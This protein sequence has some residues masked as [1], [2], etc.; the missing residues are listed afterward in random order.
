V[1]AVR[2]RDN[3]ST[4]RLLSRATTY[5]GHSRTQIGIKL[6]AVPASAISVARTGCPQLGLYNRSEPWDVCDIRN[7]S[8][9]L[10]NKT[11][12]Q[13][14]YHAMGAEQRSMTSFS[15][16]CLT[17]RSCA[18]VV[19]FCCSFVSPFNLQVCNHTRFWAAW[20]SRSFS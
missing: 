20:P 19:L 11:C 17:C 10:T 5:F 1:S 13:E 16:K 7:E 6:Q 4:A 12:Y 3:G 18:D 9:M 15:S 14:S 2:P 8:K